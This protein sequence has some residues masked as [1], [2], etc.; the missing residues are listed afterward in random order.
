[1]IYEFRTY[2]AAPGKMEALLAR[3][4]DHTDR[5]FDKHGIRS[6][7]YWTSNAEGEENQLMYLLAFDNEQQRGRA[8]AAFLADPERRAIFDVSDKEGK[9]V[10]NLTTRVMTPTAFSKLR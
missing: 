6:I 10:S 5:F 1:M 8:W 4:R 9:L 7:G 3:F 2:V